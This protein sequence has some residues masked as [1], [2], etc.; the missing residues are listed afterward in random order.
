MAKSVNQLPSI[1]GARLPTE[2]VRNIKFAKRL[3]QLMS[4]REMSQSDVARAI[5]GQ[6]RSSEGKRV[7]KGRDRLSVWCSGRDTPNAQNLE[8]LAKALKMEVSKLAPEATLKAVHNRAADW[9]ITKP[10]GEEGVSFFQAARYVPDD[11]AHQI[12]GLLIKADRMSKGASKPP[13]AQRDE[14]DG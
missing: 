9:S 2:R 12:F 4:E 14:D 13:K 7:A 1:A 8:K 3:R 5:W 6:Y 10:H 11:I